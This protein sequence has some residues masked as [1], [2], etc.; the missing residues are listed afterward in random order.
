VPDDL[1]EV[2]LKLVKLRSLPADSNGCVRCD[3]VIAHDGYA[4][5]IYCYKT[6]RAHRIVLEKK[7][8]RPIKPGYECCHSCDTPNCVNENHLFEGT[9]RENMLDASDKG[10]LKRYRSEGK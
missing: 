10:R 1:L 4:R 6:Y 8:G 9:H 2:L 7:L 3:S 5:I